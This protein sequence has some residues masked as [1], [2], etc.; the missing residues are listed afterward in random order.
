MTQVAIAHD[1]LTQRGGA[2]R[3]V[4][5]MARA[6][7]E[8]PLYTSLYDAQA[9]YPEFGAMDIRTSP[10]NLS[11][12][13][14][15]HHRLGLPLFAP[16]FSAKRVRADVVLCSTSAWAHG[17][18]T[19]GAKLVYCHTPARWL[20]GTRGY[21]RSRQWKAP[22]TMA[23]AAALG[24]LRPS[25]RRWDRRAAGRASRYLCNSV[26]VRNQ[27]RAVYGID[28]EV[29]PPPPGLT[30]L[31]PEEPLAGVEPGYHLVVSRMMPYKNVLA[32][33]EAFRRLPAERL[34]VIGDGPDWEGASA[35]AGVNV[36]LH[37]AVSDAQLRWAY[38]HAATMVCGAW[39]DFGLVPIEAAQFGVP[40]LA[41]RWGGFLDTVV[42]GETGLFVDEPTPSAITDG[43]R[44]MVRHR[45]EPAT[46]LTQASRFTEAAFAARLRELTAEVGGVT[47]AGAT[48]GH[49]V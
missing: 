9:T 24:A 12:T 19:H 45:W 7:P 32:V 20:Y 38:R 33:V 1:Y 39:E 23:A 10:L 49:T 37:R 25:L 22:A 35:L 13:I 2:E 29:L 18:R 36:T 43:V 15:H 16:A 3:V 27:V 17:I 21:L 46:L 48:A 44:Q 34:V 28:A 5:A 30:P 8:A 47:S 40:T 26:E 31:G 4:L 42:E 41:L 6:F 11:A 14:R